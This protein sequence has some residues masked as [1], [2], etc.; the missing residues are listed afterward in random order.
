MARRCVFFFFLFFFSARA[1]FLPPPTCVLNGF[2]PLLRPRSFQFRCSFFFFF[3]FSFFF[4]LILLVAGARDQQER[5]TQER[6]VE[7]QPVLHANRWL[8]EDEL[9]RQSE[10]L[11]KQKRSKKQVA[12]P[13]PPPQPRPTLSPSPSP[14]P[15]PTPSPSPPPAPPAQQAVLRQKSKKQRV[16][17]QHDTDS[18]DSSST[19]HSPEPVSN[20]GP[21]L[22]SASS[23]RPSQRVVSL[24]AVVVDRPAVV[25][26]DKAIMEKLVRGLNDLNRSLAVGVRFRNGESVHGGGMEK[27]QDIVAEALQMQL[28]EADV[29]KLLEL[30]ADV[31]FRG[32]VMDLRED[33]ELVLPFGEIR[34][35]PSEL[36]SS[37]VG[38]MQVKVDR[39][40]LDTGAAPSAPAPRA[41]VPPLQPS[42]VVDST[43]EKGMDSVPFGSHGFYNMWR[44]DMV[45]TIREEFRMEDASRRVADPAA[46]ASVPDVGRKW[47][48]FSD[49]VES[50][51]FHGLQAYFVDAGIC[52][53]SQVSLRL[54]LFCSFS[55]S[56][57]L[58][59][60]HEFTGYYENSVD[61]L[62]SKEWRCCSCLSLDVRQFATGR[63]PCQGAAE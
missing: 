60:R 33:V 10:Q 34:G 42:N 16:A 8:D 21:P 25:D 30:A 38:L 52:D 40:G 18:S 59:G 24:S 45:K 36:H 57:C 19:T 3:F 54:C 62:S 5:A 4:F 32:L 46:A 9:L 6:D 35:L 50:S 37:F 53:F 41:S 26:K 7:E 49:P 1:F 20:A 55:N 56:L 23:L 63:T 43:V 2:A 39:L 47:K 44:S 12:P 61:F 11:R 22:S 58:R 13:P 28:P 27:L 51:F 31:A 14:P 48:R 29:S 15:L 17:V